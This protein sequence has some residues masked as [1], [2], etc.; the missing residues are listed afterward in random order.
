MEELLPA[1]PASAG[2]ARRFVVEALHQLRCEAAADIAELL[3]SELV[4]NALLHGHSG[5]RLRVQGHAARV[6]VEVLD[7]SPAPVR[8]RAFSDH[9]TTGRGLALVDALAASWGSDTLGG[10]GKC[11]WFELEVGEVS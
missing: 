9:S 8:L 10:N 1:S 2:R 4:T 5:V 7:D 6:R 3:V 11:V